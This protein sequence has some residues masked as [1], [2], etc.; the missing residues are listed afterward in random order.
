MHKKLINLLNI[1]ALACVFHAMFA[2]A[3]KPEEVAGLLTTMQAEKVVT[4]SITEIN[5]YQLQKRLNAAPGGANAQRTEQLKEFSTLVGKQ[6]E[7]KAIGTQVAQS[8]ADELTT[9][10]VAKLNAFFQTPA[11]RH[12]V[13]GYQ[14]IAAPVAIALDAFV[15]TL[16]DDVMDTPDKPL[17]RIKSIDANE[18]VASRLVAKMRSKTEQDA[19][20]K[21]REQMLVKIEQFTKPEVKDKK[22]AAQHKKRMTEFGET[23]SLQQIT[24]R[25][26]RVVNQKM[27]PEQ[28]KQLLSALDDASVVAALQKLNS[29]SGK[30]SA[31]LTERMMSSPEFQDLIGRMLKR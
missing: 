22:A 29:A 10:D 1:A 13:D 28:V 5:N 18:M 20:A 3:A 9:E 31:V 27:A 25:T 19:F 21:G 12:Y 16:I 8:F 4:T 14:Y 11:G 30:V 7:W 23:Y 15:D 26:A 6:L 24:W 2:Y 17:D